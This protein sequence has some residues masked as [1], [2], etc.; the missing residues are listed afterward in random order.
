M[1]PPSPMRRIKRCHGSCGSW[2]NCVMGHMGHGS[3]KMTHFHL[4]RRQS[5]THPNSNRPR[6]RA[7]SLDRCC[8]QRVNHYTPRRQPASFCLFTLGWTRELISI[9]QFRYYCEGPLFQ[10]SARTVFY[11]DPNTTLT[12][13]LILT[14]ALGPL[15]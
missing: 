12:L 14:L 3:R 6:R 5:V 2:V 4:C 1:L 13:Y 15:L 7:T 10:R 8:D 11:T 9:I